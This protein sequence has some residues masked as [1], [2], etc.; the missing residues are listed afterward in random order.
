MTITADVPSVAAEVAE[1][2]EPVRRRKS[3]AS[4][5]ARNR[6]ALAGL[7]FIVLLV[8]AALLAPLLAPYPPNEQDF[9]ATALGPTADHWLGTDIFGR[10]VLSRL[11]YGAR[12]SL[13]AGLEA[14]A[15]ATILGS[16]LGLIAGYVGGAVDSLLSFI[17]NTILSVPGLVLAIA[18]VASLGAGLVN[19]MFAIGIVMTPRFF[20]LVRTSTKDLKAETFIRASI[21]IGCPRRRVLWAHILP[22]AMPPMLVQI[23]FVL[24]TAMLAEATLS[25]LGLGVRPPTASWGSMLAD[26]ASRLDRPNL[27]W[28]PGI[29][30]SMSILAFALVGD[31]LRDAMGIGRRSL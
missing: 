14:V 10:D 17:S 2:R 5:F 13:L 6:V 22:N 27:L 4:R 1:S 19:A 29:A 21:S 7:A 26:A 3:F 15:I 18:V 31:G 16:V 12:V 24:G 8:L 20:R 11:L 9:S 30:L 28:A 25:Y 23:S